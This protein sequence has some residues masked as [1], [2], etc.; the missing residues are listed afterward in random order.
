MS[1]LTDTILSVFKL[2]SLPFIAVTVEINV[3]LQ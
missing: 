1:E 2:R 3:N